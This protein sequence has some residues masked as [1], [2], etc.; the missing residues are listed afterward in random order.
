MSSPQLIQNP[1]IPHSFSGSIDST[2][3]TSVFQLDLRSYSSSAANISL[4]NT[5]GDADL[6]VFREPTTPGGTRTSVGQSKNTGLLSESVLLDTATL[7][8]GIYSVEVTLGSGATNAN[9]NLNVAVNANAIFNNILWRNTSAAQAGVWQMNNA[10]L[11]S[12]AS[13]GVSAE[14]SVQAV[15]DLNGDGEDDMLWR[16]TSNGQV[17][18]WLM[19][20]G[21]RIESG[22][23]IGT[24]TPLDWQIVAVK[25][26]DGNRQADIV[27][28]NPKSQQ[29][30]LWLTSGGKYLTG[31][32]YG[33]APNW[34]PV[35]SADFNDDTKN[36]IVFQNSTT[37]EMGIWL[38][39]GTT[40]TDAAAFSSGSSWRPQFYGDLNGDGQDDIVWRDTASGAVAFWLMNGV[41][42]SA[43]WAIAPVALD[44]QIAGLGDFDGSANDKKDLLWRNT[45]T[46]DL[47]IWLF[48]DAG[49]G[50]ASQKF[51]TLNGSNYN[52][53]ADWTIAGIGDFNNDGK[54]DILYRS[55]QQSSTQ[56]L[57]M[58][59]TTIT[60]VQDLNK[61][62][63][64]W[65]IQ[66]VMKRQ[67][68]AT[69]F[70]ISGRTTTDGFNKAIAYDLGLMNGS[71]AYSGTVQP[72]AS[73]YFTFNVSQLSTVTLGVT[74]PQGQTGVSLQLFR[75]LP[76]GTLGAAIAASPEMSL[77]IGAYAVKLS[78][79]AKANLS[80]TLNVLG[81]PQTTDVAGASFSM[82]SALA[83]NPTPLDSSG[84]PTGKPSDPNIVS[85]T[86][87]IVNNGSTKL[88]GVQV[89]FRISRDGQIQ[90]TAA[91]GDAVVSIDPTSVSGASLSPDSTIYTL[92][93][94]LAAG[95]TSDPITLKLIL[96]STADKFWYAD[97]NYTIGMVVDPN[98]T[99]SE[100]NEL[101]NFNVA[102]GIDKSTLGITK[103]ETLELVGTGL[104]SA[105]TG[106]TG[107]GVLTR[108]QNETTLKVQFKVADIGN[109]A[110]P[111]ASVLPIR[112]YLSSSPTLNKDNDLSLFIA[113]S[114]TRTF[115]IGG[116]NTNTS[117]P[118]V[119]AA[120]AT[121]VNLTL[122]IPSISDP[123][124]GDGKGTFYIASWIDP[125]GAVPNEADVTNNTIDPTTLGTPDDT[126]GKNYLKFTLS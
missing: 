25:D 49:T 107:T 98:N 41:T 71:G 40:R 53:G 109:K 65:Q 27:W 11:A 52:K 63:S 50:F 86:F 9:Y 57:V 62:D 102:L 69:A 34:K 66:G 113:E 26:L 114:G 90:T 126:I 31:A 79:T 89:G 74:Q 119:G 15:A 55:A 12:A 81:R 95:A 78:A 72:S 14:W 18:Y 84:Q 8:P 4:A 117:V 47:A 67:L 17:G 38:M 92:G 20:A 46:G 75:V 22:N 76:D 36:D 24:P 23:S 123:I 104:T 28:F 10:T 122:T 68:V 124:W 29:L 125:N 51:V 3:P 58:D 77:D 1:L 43:A 111:S 73:D 56:V 116:T 54:D 80:Y 37:G 61:T 101:N 19:K 7:T 42:R 2:N 21:Q 6:Q 115:N 45:K 59:G 118:G 97:G 110:F 33:V 85:T 120:N 83:L 60:K 82:V 93:T 44:W 87:R 108:G 96:P 30:A 16:N 105:L 13:Y 70:D 100:T 94:P 121:T 106:T 99:L 64:S 32:V 5:A 35:A 48:N 112:F 39:D 91:S 88:T 103:T